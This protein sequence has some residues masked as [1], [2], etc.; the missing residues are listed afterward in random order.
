[1]PRNPWKETSHKSHELRLLASPLRNFRRE[2]QE[3]PVQ[4]YLGKIQHHPT[5]RVLLL[6]PPGWL[7]VCCVRQTRHCRRF[8]DQPDF[9]ARLGLDGPGGMNVRGGPGLGDPPGLD[10]RPGFPTLTCIMNFGASIHRMAS[11]TFTALLKF[12]ITAAGPSF[13]PHGND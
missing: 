4:I 13:E 3:N 1:M 5:S 12:E 6:P 8:H 9:D 2:L 11:L 10:A 7:L